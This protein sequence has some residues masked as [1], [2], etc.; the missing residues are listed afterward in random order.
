MHLSEKTV[1]NYVTQIY[2]ILGV[3]TR[4]EAVL[5]AVNNNIRPD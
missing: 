2:D 1:R 3:H 4:T 5:W